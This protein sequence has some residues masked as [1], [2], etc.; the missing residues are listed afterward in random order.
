MSTTVIISIIIAVIVISIVGSII[1]TK[2]E[3]AAAERR[4]KVASARFKADEAQ[5]LHDGLLK[6]GL[7]KIAYKFLLERVLANL[8]D[9]YDVDPTT[10]G[11][12][13]RISE[14]QQQ[15]AD[16][17][18]TT[19]YIEMPSAM[20]EL[21]G[22]IARLNKLIKYLV[23]LYQR[24]ALPQS[25]YEKLMPSLQ[26]TLLKFDAEG[27]IKMGHQ[28]ANDYQIGT[29]K[30]SYLHAKN[31]LLEFGEDDAYVQQQLPIVD[32]L[33]QQIAEKEGLE[34]AG[35]TSV[36]DQQADRVASEMESIDS[37]E[38]KAALKEQA[39]LNKKNMS[40]FEEKKKW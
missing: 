20:V 40:D 34:Q 23:V 36:A 1:F 32:E 28:A 33:L 11:I 27:Y 15:I 10:P 22:L 7:D 31:K 38:R 17:D 14:T 16:I 29:A 6:A 30:Q 9:A 19:Y 5:D 4:Q 35:V 26:R 37:E 39:E 18:N 2:K 3:A 24:R 21:Q 25:A 12:A 13:R 8:Q